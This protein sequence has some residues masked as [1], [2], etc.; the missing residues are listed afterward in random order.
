[1]LLSLLL[2][3]TITSTVTVEGQSA[4]A[5]DLDLAAIAGLTTTGIISRTSGGAMSTRT[6]TGTATRISVNEGGGVSGNPTIDLI[7]TA[8]TLGDYNTES[9]TSVAGTQTVNTK[10]FS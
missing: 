4:Q 2:L 1:M 5:Y 7:T 6:I 8:V 9:L 10:I 3:Q